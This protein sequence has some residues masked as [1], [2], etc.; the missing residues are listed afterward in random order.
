MLHDI[1]STLPLVGAALVVV[2][3]VALLAAFL[4]V[5]LVRRRRARRKAEE[6]RRLEEQ[7][8]HLV[9]S[10]SAL[11]LAGTIEGLRLATQVARVGA[12]VGR[13]G[14]AP[15]LAGSLRLLADYAE[16]DRPALRRVLAD[17]GSV[18][19]MF[20]DIEGSTAL[21]Q[22]LG[23]DAW[24]ELLQ[25]H[26]A[27]V[28]RWVRKHRGQVVKTQGDSFMVAFRELPPALSCAVAIQRELEEKGVRTKPEIR[29]RIGLHCGEVTR[30]GR[31]VFGL[32]VALAARV[33][34]E[35]SGGEVLVSSDIKRLAGGAG[36]FSF[37][38]PRR[39]Q[40]K[41]ISDLATVYPLRW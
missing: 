38:R 18:V 36:D 4:V 5:L 2:I 3:A 7:S 22:E 33:A 14:L 10:S 31:D 32:N 8:R 15:A 26:D 12:E 11:A 16:S 25:E 37:G 6:A 29:V 35:A 19:L 30:Q 9:G 1:W 13:R 23:D 34:A 21:N 24:L 20:S 27:I 39:V 28:R 17:D 41:G 40:L